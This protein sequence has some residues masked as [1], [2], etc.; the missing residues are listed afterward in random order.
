MIIL[1]LVNVIIILVS[2]SIIWAIKN[3]DL[4][5]WRVQFI[6][7]RKCMEN[8]I[9]KL[10]NQVKFGIKFPTEQNYM[11]TYI[12]SYS[13]ILINIQF[14]YI[15]FFEKLNCIYIKHR[16]YFSHNFSY[17]KLTLRFSVLFYYRSHIFNVFAYMASIDFF[18]VSHLSYVSNFFIHLII[19]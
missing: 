14:K 1:I 6:A 18:T 17:Y 2:V 19:F 12:N 3:K 7:D 4:T 5:F 16:F 9:L 13:K 10:K 15:Y 8:H 11:Q